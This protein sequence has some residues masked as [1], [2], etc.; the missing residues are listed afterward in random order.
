MNR[1]PATPCA[2][3][4]DRL[5]GDVELFSNIVDRKKGSANSRMLVKGSET[6]SI[7]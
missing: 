1:A 4:L 7:S 6:A 2:A 3:A 5:A